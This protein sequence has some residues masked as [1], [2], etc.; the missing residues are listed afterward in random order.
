[1][2]R[3]ILYILTAVCVATFQPAAAQKQTPPPGGKAKD[4]KLSAKKV[5][6]A[7]NGLK[8]VVV[9]AST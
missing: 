9:A 5:Q 3:S 7:A 6:T 2:K 4:F 1:M 8:T